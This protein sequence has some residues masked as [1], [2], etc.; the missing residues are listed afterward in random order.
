MN[1]NTWKNKKKMSLGSK[2]I[3]A[4][5]LA[6]ALIAQPMLTSARAFADEGTAEAAATV[7]EPKVDAPVVE[8]PAAEPAAEPVAEPAEQSEEVASDTSADQTDV[9][10]PDDQQPA[11]RDVHGHRVQSGIRDGNGLQ[12]CEYRG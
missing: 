1:R 2:R 12:L 4:F 8:E 6:L 5:L 11:V 9:A 3:L 10:A 7:E